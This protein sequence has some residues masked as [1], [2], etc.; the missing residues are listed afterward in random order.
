MLDHM[1]LPAPQLRFVCRHIV[2]P[3]IALPT[4][5]RLSISELC[6]RPRLRKPERTKPVN[7]NRRLLKDRDVRSAFQSEISNILG[8]T[9]PEEVSS[10]DLSNLIRSAPVTAAKKVLPHITKRKYPPEFS[11]ETIKHISGLYGAS[12][13]VRLNSTFQYTVLWL[14]TR[15]RLMH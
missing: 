3:V 10:E 2:A 9:A 14:T 1:F 12:Q 13:N 15:L 7:L 6:F 8:E 5:H 4:D 11:A